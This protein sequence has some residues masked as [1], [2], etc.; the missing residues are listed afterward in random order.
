VCFAWVFF[1][2]PTFEEAGALLSQIA[3][4]G[5]SML[6]IHSSVAWTLALGF[7]L[8]FVP[9]RVFELTLSSFIK[10][11]APMQAL[12]LFAFALVLK[13]LAVTEVVPFIYF[14]F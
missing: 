12:T 9:R 10:L 8:H 6:N 7:T 5:L 3:G 2:A 1:R 14:Q 13:R 11:P 4:G